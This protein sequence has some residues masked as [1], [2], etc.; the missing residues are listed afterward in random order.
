MIGSVESVLVE[1]GEV[2][3]VTLNR[4]DALNAL[5]T[6][7]LEGLEAAFTGLDARAV[8]LTGAGR[9]FCA[10][11]DLMERNEMDRDAW[12]DHH[13]VLRRAFQVVRESAAPT[14]AAVEGYAVA[15]GFE[16]AL[17]CDLIVAA[18]DVVFGLP[19]VTRGI[20][21]GAGATQ[22]LPRAIAKDLILT[23]RWLP[24]AEAER[25][26][27]VARLVEPGTALAEART[28]AGQIAANAPVAVRA[29]KRAIDGRQNEL[30]AYWATV[31]S[32]DRVE[33]I[34]SFVEGREP[35][36]EGR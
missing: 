10:G 20:M 15:G 33:G 28:L 12:R 24:A 16:L 3:V 25:R 22:V 8:V 21:P 4:P 19:E 23:G 14:I 2:T 18:S 34:R 31:D 36:F 35:R 7:L 9:A 11:A 32:E 5:D 29:A 13:S 17:S 1:P 27:V 30:G 26:D 6:A